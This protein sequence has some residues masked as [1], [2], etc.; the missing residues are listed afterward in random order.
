VLENVVQLS[1]VLGAQWHEV[2]VVLVPD[3][4][5]GEVMQVPVAR[6]PDAVA[7]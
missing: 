2:F 1:V 4:D 3:S 5:V 6:P 7:D